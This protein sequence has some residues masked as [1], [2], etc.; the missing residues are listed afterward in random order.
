MSERM[1]EVLRY[2]GSKTTESRATAEAKAMLAQDGS[3]F[4]KVRRVETNGNVSFV[5]VVYFASAGVDIAAMGDGYDAWMMS[6]EDIVAGM[7]S[8]AAAKKRAKTRTR[9][10]AHK[11]EIRATWG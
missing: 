7:K 1:V 6:K 5:A 3:L 9:N 10:E 11:A 4:G 8:S 2:T